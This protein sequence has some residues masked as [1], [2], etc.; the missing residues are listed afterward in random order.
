MS[1]N[2]ITYHWTAGRNIPNADE[3]S[4]YHFLIDSNGLVYKG[5]FA[6]EDNL[7]CAD[8]KYAQ[9]CGGGNTGNIGIAFCGCYV[10]KGIAVKNSQFPLAQIQLERGFK[11]GAELCK[12]YNIPIDKEHI[13]THYEFGLTHPKTSSAG[14][15]DITYMHPFPTITK[16]ACGNFI[17]TKVKWYFLTLN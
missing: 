17:R 9:H 15:I 13:F 3:M 7:N 4:H 14:K 5:K 11:L 1:L 12:K 8:G 16:V 2:K 6:P 10:P